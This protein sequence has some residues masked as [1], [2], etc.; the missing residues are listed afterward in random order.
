MLAIDHDE[1]FLYPHYEPVLHRL[2]VEHDKLRSRKR[3]R[4]L[5]VIKAFAGHVVNVEYPH[6]R[7]PHIDWTF[8][9]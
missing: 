3:K 7:H 4:A 9:R 6:H 5:E 8:T 2:Q 1:Y